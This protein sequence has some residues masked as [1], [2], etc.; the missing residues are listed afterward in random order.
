MLNVTVSERARST[1]FVTL[2]KVKATMGFATTTDAARDA[3]LDELIADASDAIVAFCGRTFAREEVTEHLESA[4]RTVLSLDRTPVAVVSE[5]RFVDD[6]IVSD[7]YSLNDA[8]AGMLYKEDRW[9]STKPTEQWIT[10]ERANEPGNQ[11]WHV[12][13]IGGYLMP[14]DDFTASGVCIA[15][16][17]DFI[18]PALGDDDSFPILVSGER[19]KFAGFS[20]AANNG[21]FTV[22]ARTRARVTVSTAL[23]YEAPS[24]VIVITSRL[25]GNQV[26]PRDIERYALM[27][28]QAW[29]KKE[30]RDSDITSESI[31]DWSAA[32]ASEPFSAKDN[33]GLPPTVAEGLRTRYARVYQG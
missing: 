14:A 4:G 20:N 6:I 10:S 2:S 7:D 19:I 3:R 1:G 17:T 8:A 25:N 13:Y 5:V 28:V 29:F 21:I 11:D 18:L 33:F 32:Y 31:G 30:R 24:G 15:S 26:L 23:T 22:Q 27:T 12:D 9:A 16:G